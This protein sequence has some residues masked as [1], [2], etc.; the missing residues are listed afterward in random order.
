[1][2]DTVKKQ[3]FSTRLPL[4]KKV[5]TL[6]KGHSVSLGMGQM[7]AWLNMLASSHFKSATVITF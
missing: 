7:T 5:L 6:L 3:M 2:W 4:I 1:M